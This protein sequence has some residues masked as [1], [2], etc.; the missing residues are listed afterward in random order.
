MKIYYLD[1]SGFAVILKSALLVF[2]YYLTSPEN[3]SF[4]D[5]VI[6][7]GALNDFERVYFFVSHKHSDHF[8][9]NIYSLDTN[10]NT[11]FI[12]AMGTPKNERPEIRTAMK[13]YDVFDD[14]YISVYAG[15]STDL[16]VSFVIDAEGKRFFHAGDL[17]CWHWI[18]DWDEIQEKNARGYFTK[19]LARLKPHAQNIDIAFFPVDPRMKGA[20][21]DGAREF[22]KKYAP[23][24]FIPMHCQNKFSVIYKF[25]E[26]AETKNTKVLCYNK[27]GD[28]F[29]LD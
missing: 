15:G 25:K 17:N 28:M 9:K 12:V 18:G 8:N 16:G 23:K 5:G 29:E 22:L 20:Y 19:A 14:G 2:D 7:R 3:G 21:D 4:E 24:Y 13:E 27:R 10:P 1:N 11:R 26:D 6:P